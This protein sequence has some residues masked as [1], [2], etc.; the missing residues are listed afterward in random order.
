VSAGEYICGHL[1][2]STS[3]KVAR[4]MIAKREAKE[5]R[6]A[7]EAKVEAMEQHKD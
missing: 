6:E 5:T 1:G 4:A 3:S 2:K 7:K